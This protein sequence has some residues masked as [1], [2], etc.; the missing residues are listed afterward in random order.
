MMFAWSFAARTVDEIATLLRALGKHRYVREVDHRLHFAVDYALA[1]LE[2]FA[3]RHAELE[4]RAVTSRITYY[5]RMVSALYLGR[6]DEALEHAL[7][8]AETRDAIGPIWYR[9]PDLEPLQA[10]PRYPEVLAR[11]RA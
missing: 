9:W 6:N 4:A 10:H 8:S 2:P 5:S 11:L 1:P 3:S 7:R